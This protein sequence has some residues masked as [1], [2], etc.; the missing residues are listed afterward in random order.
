[1]KDSMH[2]DSRPTKV[3]LRLPGDPSSPAWHHAPQSVVVNGLVKTH[4]VKDIQ[5]VSLYLG[6][7]HKIDRKIVLCN[8]TEVLHVALF[9]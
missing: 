9:A 3:Q 5:R 8:A 6:D 7:G 1:M 4:D 2:K